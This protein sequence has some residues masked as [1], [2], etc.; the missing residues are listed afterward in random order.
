MGEQSAGT[1]SGLFLSGKHRV[2]K[3]H[4][5]FVGVVIGRDSDAPS[6]IRQTREEL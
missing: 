5:F 2:E 1:S 3:R 6:S 4:P